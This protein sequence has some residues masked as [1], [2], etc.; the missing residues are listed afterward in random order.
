MQDTT[1]PK[2]FDLDQVDARLGARDGTTTRLESLKGLYNSENDQLEL[3]GVVRVR[4]EGRY[5]ITLK[6]ASVD[7]KNNN[8]VSNE[9]VVATIPGGRIEA[10]SLTY[11]ESEQS[12]AFTG[13]VHSEFRDN[14]DA[15]PEASAKPEAAQ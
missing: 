12:L 8:I 13:S 14:D 15:A 2:L 7:M 6:H 4:S 11:S 9:P 10:D 3:S 1:K 5:D